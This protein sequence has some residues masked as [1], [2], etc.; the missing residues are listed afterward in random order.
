MN[1]LF[2][3]IFYRF[4]QAGAKQGFQILLLVYGTYF[5]GLDRFGEY[6]YIS[7][8]VVSFSILLDFGL[9]STIVKV[10]A[11]DSNQKRK[12]IGTLIP[13]LIISIF[14]ISI[15][16]FLILYC[17]DFYS[18]FTS[19]LIGFML[20]LMPICALFEGYNRGLLRFKSNAY[21]TFISSFL[22]LV[23][24]IPIV[25]RFEVDG[26]LLVQ[27]IYYST[28]LILLFSDVF[29]SGH[30]H[31]FKFIKDNRFIFDVLKYSFLIG[32]ASIGQI[33]YTKS[34]ILVLGYYD[35]YREISQYE[36]IDRFFMYLIIPVALLGQVF[37]PRVVNFSRR[38]ITRHHNVSLFLILVFS[39]LLSLLVIF[40]Y[41]N[42]NYKISDSFDLGGFD[43]ILFI[44]IL[45]LPFKMFAVFQTQSYIN[46]LGHAAIIA[47]TTVFFGFL[48]VILDL[49]LVAKY[50]FIGVFYSTA[51]VIIGNT[52]VQTIIFRA[53]IKN[54][55]IKL[56]ESH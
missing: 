24:L 32:I 42:Y 4:F 36:V 52:V 44:F 54:D 17:F 34:D 31:D 26:L 13:F 39:A 14:T 20:F 53:K 50:G 38:K 2:L 15:L 48:N 8:G 27:V 3:D 45:A 11:E 28:L 16:T 23:L 7:A 9:S 22:S 47:K 25:N 40:V 21:F 12:V 29:R 6:L 49:L 35:Y 51:F 19:M 37:A 30:Y 5:L 18:L 56:S 33:L 10:I 43:L 1:S 46:P 41:D 55:R